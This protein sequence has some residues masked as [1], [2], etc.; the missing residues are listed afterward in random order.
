MCC[1][2]VAVYVAVCAV[3]SDAVCV[4]GCTASLSR[5]TTKF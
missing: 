5:S 3:V 4:V 1:S 2:S